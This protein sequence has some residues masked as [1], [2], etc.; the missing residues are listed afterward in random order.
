MADVRN[1]KKCGRIFQ[2]DGINKKCDRCRKGEEEDFARVK[3][4]LYDHPKATISEVA[5]ETEVEEDLILR[6]LRQGRLEIVGEGGSLVLDCE[7]CGRSIKTGRFCDQCTHEMTAELKAAFKPADRPKTKDSNKM[8]T[9]EM[10][11]KR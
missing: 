3:E 2:Y 10:K 1:C 4:Y 11:K 6:Y 5:Q 7:R 8:F 9:A